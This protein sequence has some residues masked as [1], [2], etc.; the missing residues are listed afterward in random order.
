MAV[1]DLDGQKGKCLR[2]TEVLR[3]ACDRSTLGMRGWR[4]ARPC[5]S[6]TY[7]IR[8]ELKYNGDTSSSGIP[9]SMTREEIQP[10]YIEV[11]RCSVDPPG[12]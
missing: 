12:T 10:K 9:E 4:K 3:P 2:Y 7:K 8:T 1:Y 5:T 6:E 11:L